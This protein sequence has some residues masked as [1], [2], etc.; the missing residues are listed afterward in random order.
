MLS[1]KQTFVSLLI[2]MRLLTDYIENSMY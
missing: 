1:C 2:K